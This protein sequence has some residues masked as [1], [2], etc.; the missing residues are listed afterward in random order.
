MKT[1]SKN[2]FI[3]KLVFL[4][5]FILNVNASEYKPT[6]E[7]VVKLYV[8]T[9]NRAP[10]SDGLAYWVNDSKLKLSQIAQSFFDQ[11]E[12][13]LL[14]PSNTSNRSFINSV[15]QN[16]FNRTPDD[17]GWDY[18]ENELNRGA[19]SRNSFIQ[20]V[21]N[22]AQD[23]ETSNDITILN[24]KKDVGLYFSNQGLK[25]IADAKEVMKGISDSLLSVMFIKDKIIN[26]KLES[27]IWSLYG[28]ESETTGIL[29]LG[30][31]KGAS[32]SI[33]ALDGYT[34]MTIDR[35]SDN[36]EF[37]IDI[38]RLKK[39][40]DS[41]NPNIKLVK[42]VSTGGIDT[43]YNDDGVKVSS[44]NKSVYSSIKSIIPLNII[45]KTNGYRV[46]FITSMVAEILEKSENIDEKYINQIVKKL[47]VDDLNEDGKLTMEDIIYYD[48]VK[49]DSK[50]ESELR[51]RYLD[52]FHTGD[53]SKKKQIIDE[54]KHS[55]GTTKEIIKFNGNNFSVSLKA[56]NPNNY[57]LYGITKT[58]D[59]PKL[60]IYTDTLLVNDALFV[61]KECDIN[62]N[63]S[64]LT[65]IF[66][67][68]DKY[69]YDNLHEQITKSNINEIIDQIK[70]LNNEIDT[71]EK[72][73]INLDNKVDSKKVISE[74]ITYSWSIGTWGS[75][76]GECGLNNATQKREISCVS[77]N[78]TIEDDSYCTNAKPKTIQKCTANECAINNSSI[79]NTDNESKIT[80]NTLKDGLVAHYEFEGNAN[81]SSGNGNNGIE[82]GNI[83][84]SKGVIGQAV[85]F[86][87]IASDGGYK[88]PDRIKINNN[89]SLKFDRYITISYWVEI[90]GNKVQTSANCSGEAI[91]GI[92]GVILGKSG[93]RNGMYIKV[94]DTS[95]SI[96]FQP[97]LGGKGGG[98]K[99]IDSA[100][101]TFRYET[102]VID[103]KTNSI[104]IYINGKFKEEKIGNIDFSYSNN[105]DLYIGA[106]YNKYISGIGGACLDYWYPLDGLID[107]LRIYNRILTNDEINALYN[108]K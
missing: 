59:E 22:G 52:T 87:G 108:L 23:T 40:V 41:Y 32:I 57:I 95:T 25:N 71:I 58:L 99:N 16:L 39:E 63:C 37:T 15:Y 2:N 62:D 4:I 19:F 76:T 24:N 88:N 28:N 81:D 78:G 107:D 31:T 48:M 69:Y 67:E 74:I 80:Y 56:S 82:Y 60:E 7:E 104:K 64:K 97:Y 45:Y 73:I 91:T 27:N 85:N 93:D 3:T 46:N 1:K 83:S 36:G 79:S 5:I 66:F 9:F 50:V 102:Y 13:Q 26:N 33:H 11:K 38:N 106:T 8:A 29:E 75:C 90:K 94:S 54:Y 35:T 72:E 55:L 10:D 89:A 77:S 43:D 20:A 98:V 47:D 100:Y 86:N 65:S 21:I 34:L 105:R 49:N 53:E 84:Y 70:Y 14:Y 17:D 68:N 92:G 96:G 12:T 103:S 18:W 51:S 44:E 6:E 61:Y 42:L 101:K 30:R